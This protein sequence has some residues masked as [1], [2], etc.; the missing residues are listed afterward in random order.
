VSWLCLCFH[1][2]GLIYSADSFQWR[3]KT[4]PSIWEEALSLDD[5]VTYTTDFVRPH[6]MWAA[7]LAFGESPA[8][9]SL[10]L[11]ATVVL[12]APGAFDLPWLTQY[13][14]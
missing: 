8:F 14:D 3:D 1:R 4:E 6:E 9:L 13:I 11:L 5:I 12:L 10:L 2:L 7:A